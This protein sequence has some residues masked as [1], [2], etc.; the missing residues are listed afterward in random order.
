MDGRI[1]DALIE[2][3]GLFYTEKK[4]SRTDLVTMER[5]ELNCSFHFLAEFVELL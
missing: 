3:T 2:G 1:N 4:K 5:A